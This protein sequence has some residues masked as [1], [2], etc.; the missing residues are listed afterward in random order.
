MNMKVRKRVIMIAVII[1]PAAV[2]YYI[3]K[4]FLHS[5]SRFEHH[6]L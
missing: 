6:H 4:H 3:I 5:A 2:I 1:P